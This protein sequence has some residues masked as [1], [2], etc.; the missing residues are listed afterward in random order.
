MCARRIA[1]AL[2]STS[3]RKVAANVQFER[4]QFIH[5]HHACQQCCALVF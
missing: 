1:R 4:A 3:F 2:R 5:A